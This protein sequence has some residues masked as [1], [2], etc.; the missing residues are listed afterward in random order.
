MTSIGDHH[1]NTA[2]AWEK[3]RNAKSK[4]SHNVDLKSATHALFG[5]VKIL[6]PQPETNCSREVGGGDI[7]RFTKGDELLLERRS[8]PQQSEHQGANCQR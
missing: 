7:R 1:F 8:A 5:F 2:A 6:R 4:L 3:G